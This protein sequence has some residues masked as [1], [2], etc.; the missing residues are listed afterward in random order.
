[1]DK[2]AWQL[3]VHGVTKVSDATYL[4]TKQ[5]KV[6]KTL[7]VGRRDL[8]HYKPPAPERQGVPIPTK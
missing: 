3:T 1:M 8:Q 4:V 5:H 2:G 7:Q 6:R